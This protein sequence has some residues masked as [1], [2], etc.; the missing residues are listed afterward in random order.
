MYIIGD[1][2]Y[3]TKHISIYG[4]V[5]LRYYFFIM[6]IHKQLEPLSYMIQLTLV[7]F[8]SKIIIQSFGSILYVLYGSFYPGFFQK[9]SDDKPNVYLMSRQEV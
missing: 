2:P 3:S 1:L 8:T 9:K 5:N 6:F 7:L 4:S